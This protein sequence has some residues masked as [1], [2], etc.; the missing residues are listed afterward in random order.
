M[1]SVGFPIIGW[2]GQLA[3]VLPDCPSR[4]KSLDIRVFF[5]YM[6]SSHEILRVVEA[7]L[8]DC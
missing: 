5:V 1:D 7:E 6:G 2:N 3:Q 4:N 8:R